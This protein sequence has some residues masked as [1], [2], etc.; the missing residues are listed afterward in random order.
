MAGRSLDSNYNA[1]VTGQNSLNME[2]GSGPH[3]SERHSL[4]NGSA[5]DLE[6]GEITEERSFG[7]STANTPTPRTVLSVDVDQSLHEPKPRP[8]T[9]V[10]DGSNAPEATAPGPEREPSRTTPDLAVPRPMSDEELDLAKSIV[11]DLLGWGVAP[12]YLIECGVSS[13]A[14]YKIFTDLHL[15]LP[16]NLSYFG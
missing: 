3:G 12:E 4:A 8:S 1:H 16:T 5:A 14:I 10:G 13:Q 15:R 6:D 7:R 9:S 11:L 2:S